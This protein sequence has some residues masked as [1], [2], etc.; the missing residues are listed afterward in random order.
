[1]G[2]LSAINI[3]AMRT[4]FFLLLL[5][6]LA[7]NA[8]NLNKDEKIVSA[9]YKNQEADRSNELV[10]AQPDMDTSTY[11]KFPSWVVTEEDMEAY[12]KHKN[13]KVI[14]KQT[15]TPEKKKKKPT[16]EAELLQAFPA[17]ISNER[18][19]EQYLKASH[20]KVIRRDTGNG[21]INPS[22]R[23]SIEAELVQLPPKYKQKKDKKDPLAWA[24]LEQVSSKPSED[25]VHN[26]LTD[27]IAE[28]NKTDLQAPKDNSWDESAILGGEQKRID[29]SE[30]RRLVRENYDDEDELIQDLLS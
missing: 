8:E 17:W 23:P 12:F 5:G 26:T 9:F 1:M 16:P 14:R 27:A 21:G 7:I 28:D 11:T 18:D 30:R 24:N 10:A 13:M 25:L 3:L 29:E 4:A 2:A 19:L 6:C 15:G 22:G 20:A